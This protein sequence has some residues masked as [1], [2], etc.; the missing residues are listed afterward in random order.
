MK[1]RVSSKWSTKPLFITLGKKGFCDGPRH[2]GCGRLKLNEPSLLCLVR[3]CQNNGEEAI[4][5][6]QQS[7]TCG[8]EICNCDFRKDSSITK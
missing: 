5:D 1:A 7:V 6:V 2:M 4:L 3:S 8:K